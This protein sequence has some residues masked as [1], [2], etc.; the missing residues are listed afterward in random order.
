MCFSLYWQGRQSKLK[1]G[2]GPNPSRSPR[3]PHTHSYI[4][5]QDTTW[6]FVFFMFY[7]SLHSIWMFVFSEGVGWFVI[8][9]SRNNIFTSYL[10]QNQ[11]LAC[12]HLCRDILNKLWK[13]ALTYYCIAHIPQLPRLSERRRTLAC[14]GHNGLNWCLLNDEFYRWEGKKMAKC[15]QF[16]VVQICTNL[17]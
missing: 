3:P 4:K 6:I 16:S 8:W 15:S 10:S 17:M 12:W 7:C 5:V 9:F 1:L 14:S 2:L 13:S 11:Y